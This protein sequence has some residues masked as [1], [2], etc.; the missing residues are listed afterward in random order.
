MSN[1]LRKALEGL[2]LELEKLQ[3][4]EKEI[5]K[6]M[7][8]I[9][10]MLGE[11][12]PFENIA[13]T[14]GGSTIRPDQF[15]GKGLAPAVKAYLLTRGRAVPAHEIL[16]GLKAGGFSIPQDWKSEKYW[17]R[18]LTISLTK[19]RNDFVYVKS[20]NSYGLW[21]FYPDLKRERGK[22]NK[23]ESTVISPDNTVRE[24]ADEEE[25]NP[26]EG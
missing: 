10:S 1:H 23:Q 6:N 12:T 7:N 22:R 19:N 26:K 5:M 2:R 4:Q 15:F 11:K 21:D 13:P 9:A 25:G 18:N 3:A 14:Q 20:S 24:E 16:E 17:L 8:S